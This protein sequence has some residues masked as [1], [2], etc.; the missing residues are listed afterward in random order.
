MQITEPS[1][2]IYLIDGKSVGVEAVNQGFEKGSLKIKGGTNNSRDAL[3]YF[4]EKYRYGINIF[5]T[6]NKQ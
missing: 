3:L 1:R 5:V 2:I 4:G 6:I